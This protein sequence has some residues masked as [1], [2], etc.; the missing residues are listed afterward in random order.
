MSRALG[1]DY[2]RSLSWG[3]GFVTLDVVQFV[4]EL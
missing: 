3:E 1:S 2:A 4:G